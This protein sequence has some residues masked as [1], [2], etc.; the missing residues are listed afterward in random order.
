MLFFHKTQFPK[1]EILQIKEMQIKIKYVLLPKLPEI[2]VKIIFSAGK[3]AIKEQVHKTIIFRQ[4]LIFESP[5]P[6]LK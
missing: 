1:D 3:V 4:K 2:Q 5:I 6:F